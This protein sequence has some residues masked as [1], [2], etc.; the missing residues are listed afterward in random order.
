M[1]DRPAL[2]YEALLPLLAA[3]D[4]AATL[5]LL[6]GRTERER[7]AVG[8]RLTAAFRDWQGF[9]ELVPYRHQDTAVAAI[10]GT[11]SLTELKRLRELHRW[12]AYCS[13]PTY[14]VLDDRRPDWLDR[15]V[16]FALGEEAKSAGR[17]TNA[18]AFVR[19]L[20][21]SGL[22][23]KPTCDAY[24]LDMLRGLGA[25]PFEYRTRWSE[26]EREAREP[27]SPAPQHP[28]GAAH[29]Q[30]FGE[31]SIESFFADDPELLDDE[32]WRLFRVRGRPS[33]M[34][35]TDEH[36]WWAHLFVRL[37]STGTIDRGRVLDEAVAA[38]GRS[39][40]PAQ[41]RWCVRLHELLETTAEERRDHVPDYLHLLASS[42]K[43]VVKFAVG[44]LATIEDEGNLDAEALLGSLDPVLLTAPKV[45][46]VA[47]LKL[48]DR[49][50]TGSPVLAPLALEVA[51]AGLSTAHPGVQDAA[52]KVIGAHWSE[53][54]NPAA[55][56]ALTAHLELVD[57]AV[58]P[59]IE[60]LVGS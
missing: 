26:W 54:R 31:R 44:T 15:W 8:P 16:D 53:G 10:F 40:P 42:E 30:R 24:T 27:G 57:P 50:A 34:L 29:R 47:A 23:A 28:D 51:I 60:I 39:F 7:R 58:R 38:M 52:A 1:A 37:A 32:I 35:N 2:T 19:L 11:A 48:L 18:W 9:R 33:R 5:E 46:A 45:T 4:D 17:A 41:L 21:R 22:C 12:G 25:A 56:E 14:A 20:T 43:A 55:V 36:E 49:V 3:G 13:E 6:R 59:R